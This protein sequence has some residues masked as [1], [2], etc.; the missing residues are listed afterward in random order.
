MTVAVRVSQAYGE[1]GGR[2]VADDVPPLADCD[3][4]AQARAP[5]DPAQ[6]LRSTPQSQTVG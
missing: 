2:Q 6:R 5:I 1:I 4:F 3:D